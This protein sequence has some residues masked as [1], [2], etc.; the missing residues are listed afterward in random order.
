[1]RRSLSYV[2]L[3]SL[4]GCASLSKIAKDVLSH[5]PE[6]II[7]LK[8]VLNQGEV[9]K[10]NIQSVSKNKI[11][12]LGKTKLFDV[13]ID[14]DLNMLVKKVNLDTISLSV[15]IERIVGNI[16][17]D[18]GSLTIPGIDKIKGKSF[19]LVIRNNGDILNT[20]KIDGLN[21]FNEILGKILCMFIFIPAKEIKIGD[22]WNKYT[23]TGNEKGNYTFTFKDL[24][25]EKKIGIIEE[26]GTI[27]QKT[28]KEVLGVNVDFNLSG[29]QTS[30]INFSLKKGIPV[31]K[32]TI[33]S[34][35][36]T[37]NIA[38]LNTP[39]KLYIDNTMTLKIK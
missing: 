21:E 7:L 2:L 13:N 24:F 22:V 5:L 4:F 33:S 19:D 27:E 29:N 3:F 20:D 31:E 32:K 12:V 39:V 38:P 14:T 8:L 25:S 30:E 17:S 9:I 37:A 10:Y 26:K 1:M 6:G 35:T 34:L 36:G 16:S 28:R 23:N 15:T 18:E 11:E